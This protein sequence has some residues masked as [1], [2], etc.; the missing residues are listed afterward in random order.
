MPPEYDQLGLDHHEVSSDAGYVF[1]LDVGRQD[2]SRRCQ[3]PA[4]HAP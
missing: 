1:G 3:A 2:K 4:P